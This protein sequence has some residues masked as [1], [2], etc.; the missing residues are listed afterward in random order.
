MAD[1]DVLNRPIRPR[2]PAPAAPLEAA[3]LE[4]E[5]QAQHA[6]NADAI[7]RATH[8]PPPF[9]PPRR[10]RTFGH[11]DQRARRRALTAACG[12]LLT[13][14]DPIIVQLRAR[15]A[16]QLVGHSPAMIELNTLHRIHQALETARAT[17]HTW[18]QAA[19]AQC[20]TYDQHP[21]RQP[22][23]GI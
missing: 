4:V 13:T 17:G 5:S 9:T 8:R 15:I 12:A 6:A 16:E 22:L 14:R 1:V 18:A 7:W 3:R 11:R 20:D 21:E 19:T 10:R 23:I 2:P